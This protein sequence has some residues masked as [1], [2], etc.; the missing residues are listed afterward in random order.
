MN[1]DSNIMEL[2]KILITVIIAFI[3]ASLTNKNESKK[4]ATIFFKQE[5]IK[6][7]QAILESWCSILLMNY[8]DTI[9]KFKENNKERLIKEYN[10]KSNQEISDTMAINLLQRD[11]YMY[12]SKI[13]VKYIG[14][15]MQE[16]FNSDDSKKSNMTK[17]MYLVSKIISSMKYDF[18]GE[19]VKVLDLIKIKIN[20]LDC[21]KKI[22][23]YYYEFLN[24][25]KM[26]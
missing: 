13:T 10:L 2:I 21:K 4:Q 12:S 5:G 9:Q 22:A 14:K 7:Q 23:I 1:I 11:S 17:Q 6:Q 19:K 20:D 3:T 26:I 18:T 15:Y 16:V 8:E 24:L 25:I